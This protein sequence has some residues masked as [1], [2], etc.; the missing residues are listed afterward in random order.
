[1]ARQG[2]NCTLSYQSGGTAHTY[3][4]RCVGLQHGVQMIFEESEARNFRAF[5]P[6][7]AAMQRFTLAIQC[8]GV[9]ERKS[10]VN[11]LS[12][13]AQYAINPDIVQDT[14]PWMTAA[15]PSRSFNQPGVPLQGYQW[16]DHVGSM[17]WNIS[18]V[19]EAATTPGSK[20]QPDV[21]SVIDSWAAFASDPAVQYFYPTGTQLSGSQLPAGNFAQPVYPGDPANFNTVFQGASSSSGAPRVNVGTGGNKVIAQ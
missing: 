5:Y 7:R 21:S 2:L 19:F 18:L 12:T 3:R 20:A 13:Y 4:V 17:L 16:G 14:F 6:H 15:V 9:A 8:K 1:M 11:W 10:L